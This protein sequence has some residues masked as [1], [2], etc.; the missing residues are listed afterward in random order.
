MTDKQRKPRGFGRFDAAMR[1]LV[2][3]PPGELKKQLAQ[4]KIRRRKK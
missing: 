3:V 4:R 2:K 1:M